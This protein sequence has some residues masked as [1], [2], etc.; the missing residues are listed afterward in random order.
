[1]SFHAL[2]ADISERFRVA[3]ER[4][5]GLEAGCLLRVNR[6]WHAPTSGRTQVRFAPDNDQI[7]R[8]A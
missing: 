1:M 8:V 7:L 3:Y 2:G 5:E 4:P 6:V